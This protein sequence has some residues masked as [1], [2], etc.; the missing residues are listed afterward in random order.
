MIDT[1]TDNARFIAPDIVLPTQLPAASTRARRMMAEYHLLVAVLEDAV[2]CFQRYVQ[3][4]SRRQRRLFRDAEAW[5]MSAHHRSNRKR[6][7]DVPGF[8]FEFVCDTLGIDADDVRRRLRRW[9]EGQ[10][11]C[12]E[13]RVHQAA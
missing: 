3:P 1:S 13:G 11:E 5:I 8:S 2:Q 4:K 9:R 7:D 6:E 12:P 10:R